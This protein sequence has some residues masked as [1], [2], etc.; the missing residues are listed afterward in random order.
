MIR[1]DVQKAFSKRAHAD[2][3]PCNQE[4][5]QVEP[6]AGREAGP[7]QSTAS[8]LSATN[9]YQRGGGLKQQSG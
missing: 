9:R 7:E 4:P 2:A 3:Y 5:D 1:A 6:A 8:A